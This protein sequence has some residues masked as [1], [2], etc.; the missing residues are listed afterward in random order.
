MSEYQGNKTKTLSIKDA[1]ESCEDMIL[2]NYFQYRKTLDLNWFLSGYDGR[3]KKIDEALLKPIEE[4]INNEY[5]TLTNTRGFEKMIQNYAKIE[6]LKTKFYVVSTLIYNVGQGFAHDKES[7]E[8]RA[9]YIEQLRLWGFK[10]NIIGTYEDDLIS[11]ERINSQLQG[12]KT[13]IKIIEDEM[14]VEGTKEV[15]SLQKQ[16]IIIGVGL[17]LN[18]KI[19][20]KDITIVDWVE[21]INIIK[22]KAKQN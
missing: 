8:I 18:Y 5:Y 15:V 12:I 10:M 13:N 6:S 1:F 19:N 11:I 16:L 20:P 21:M 17:G 3:Q 14:K 7:Q 9:K 22:E 2:Y 4:K